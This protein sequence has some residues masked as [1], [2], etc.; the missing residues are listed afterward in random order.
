MF[1][2]WTPQ[3]S[4]FSAL[5]WLVVSRSHLHTCTSYLHAYLVMC[6]CVSVSLCLCVLCHLNYFCLMELI[7]SL[8]N[9]L[10]TKL[11]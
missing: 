1:S 8:H 11:L 4:I 3:S 7:P 6:L 9:L 2:E 5:C 10:K